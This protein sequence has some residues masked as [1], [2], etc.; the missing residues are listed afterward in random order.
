[1]Q[2]YMVLGTKT[3]PYVTLMFKISV[4][5]VLQRQKGSQNFIETFGTFVD[6]YEKL[7]FKLWGLDPQR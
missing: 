6:S 4:M 7:L 5:Q 2:S 3:L 1:M